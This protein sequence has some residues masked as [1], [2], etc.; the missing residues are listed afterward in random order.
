MVPV[1]IVGIGGASLT[2]CVLAVAARSRDKLACEVSG[3]RGLS[4]DRSLPPSLLLA[5]RHRASLLGL[6]VPLS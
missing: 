1:F 4:G 5:A 6:F 2:S 3:T